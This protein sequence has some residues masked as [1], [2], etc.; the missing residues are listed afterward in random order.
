MAPNAVTRVTLVGNFTIHGHTHEVRATTQVRY[1]PGGG[2]G[3][4]DL[5]R[6]QARFSISLSDYSVSI[7]APV[8]LKVSNTIQVNVTIRATA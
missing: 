2:D 3:G 1:V 4:G 8:R 5:I 7:S 6:A